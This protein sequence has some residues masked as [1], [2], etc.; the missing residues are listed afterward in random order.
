M[1]TIKDI[2]LSGKR[3]F[4][5]VDFNV[6]LD[7]DQNITDDTRISF[8]LPTLEYILENQGRLIVASHLGRPNGEV[9]PSMSMKPVAK[10]LEKLLKRDVKSLDDCIGEGVKKVIE[11]MQN[12]DV[13]F[14]E[15]LRFYPQEQENN[16]EFAKELASFS[17]VYVN[18]AFAVS[19][20]TN[21]SVVAITKFAPVS[22]AGMLLEKEIMYF[23]QAMK[24]PKRPFAAVIGGAKISSKL[25]ALNNILKIV[26]KIIIGGAMANT[27]LKSVGCAVG[28]SMVE[29]DM[30]PVAG[31][32]MK[33]AKDKDIKFYLP[34]DAK[35]ANNLDENSNV[36]VYPIQEIPNNKSIFDIGPATSLI[37]DEAFHDVNTIIWSG[38]MGVF[39]ID[40]F[41]SG[42]MEIINSITNSKALTIAGGGDTNAAIH[43]SGKKDKLTYISTGGGAFLTLLEGKALPAVEALD[44]A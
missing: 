17:D 5:R 20:R 4:V 7:S 12:G 35:V 39:E 2:N 11:K 25:G 31:D 40:A 34:V 42:T 8:C 26:N 24:D 23:N 33:S 38:P 28:E 22:A 6:P 27:F 30:V 37:Y 36:N 15:N 43:Q 32:I 1:Q 44:K 14:L 19:H 29:K 10:R 13:V 18:D 16:D 21:A 41:S 9:V 3:V